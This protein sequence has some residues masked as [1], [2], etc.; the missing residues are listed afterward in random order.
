MA[1]RKCGAPCQ[2]RFCQVH[3]I[4]A[5]HEGVDETEGTCRTLAD[6]DG[7]QFGRAD[8]SKANGGDDS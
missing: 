3:A 1:C 4:E 2:G 8:A 7:V 5:A 6:L